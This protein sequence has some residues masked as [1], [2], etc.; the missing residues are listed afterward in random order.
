MGIGGNSQ[1]CLDSTINLLE[2]TCV[3]LCDSGGQTGQLYVLSVMLTTWFI[4]C[5]KLNCEY[6]FFVYSLF[7]PAGKKWSCKVLASVCYCRLFRHIPKTYKECGLKAT[8]SS[9]VELPDSQ[10]DVQLASEGSTFACTSRVMFC[11]WR[12]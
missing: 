3:H 6:V 5:I 8:V 2:M 9:I 10:I 12:S 1:F 4:Y 11:Q 7:S